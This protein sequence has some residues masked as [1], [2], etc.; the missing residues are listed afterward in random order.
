MIGDLRKIILHRLADPGIR[1]RSMLDQLAVLIPVIINPIQIAHVLVELIIA[2]LKIHILKDQQT[3]GHSNSQP[4]D[5]NRRKYLVLADIPPGGGEI[6]L[7]HVPG[8]KRKRR[9]SGSNVASRIRGPCWA[10]TSDPLIMS[11]LL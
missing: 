5:I 8:F 6:T 3:S 1:D 11:Q 2:Q 9:Q 4:D 7:E 10:R